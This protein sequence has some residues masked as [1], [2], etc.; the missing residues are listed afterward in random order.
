MSNFG[1]PVAEVLGHEQ[2]KCRD[3]VFYLK[4]EA[5]P[6]GNLSSGTNSH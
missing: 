1:N 5:L 2:Q 4:V 3:L 6:P